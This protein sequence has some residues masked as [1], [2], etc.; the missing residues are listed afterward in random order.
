MEM[1]PEHK[2]WAVV[3]AIQETMAIGPKGSILEIDPKGLQKYLSLAEIRQIFEKLAKDEDAI[4]LVHLPGRAEIEGLFLGDQ[5][6]ISFRIK[7]DESFRA[8]YAKAHAQFF[9]GPEKMSGENFFA[10]MDVTQDIHEELEMSG[11]NEVTIPI[12]RDIIRYSI[13]YPGHSPNMM[14]R[15]CRLRMKAVRYLK[16]KGHI[17]DYDVT[18]ENWDS[19]ITISLDRLTFARFFK[20]LMDVYPEKVKSGKDEPVVEQH[21]V[22]RFSEGILRRDGTDAIEKFGE[23]SHEHSVLRVA[24]DNPLKTRI[25]NATPGIEMGWDTLYDTA[26]RLNKKIE[27]KFGVNGFFRTEFKDKY[28]ERTV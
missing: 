28:I 20:R 15:Y 12:K 7:N 1:P 11:A 8:I 22:F 9:G 17:K 10:V 16:E 23:N 21:G 14:D 4:D 25:D 26:R 18:R 5:K 19:T 13:L 3:D 24:F 2:I 27:G 6:T